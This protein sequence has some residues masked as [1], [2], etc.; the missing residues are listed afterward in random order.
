M[1]QPPRVVE[2]RLAAPAVVPA[3]QPQLQQ[4]RARAEAAAGHFRQKRKVLVTPHPPQRDTPAAA[5]DDVLQ[6]C[7]GARRPR[8]ASDAPARRRQ[9][10]APANPAPAARAALGAGAGGGEVHRRQAR[11]SASPGS[12][13]TWKSTVAPSARRSKAST[14]SREADAVSSAS[15]TSSSASAGGA[16]TPLWPRLCFFHGVA[17]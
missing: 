11:Q 8:S 7:G 15:T 5:V 3:R 13:H 17:V 10:A 6:R 9:L 12:S 1:L 4:P 14:H 2:P 16:V